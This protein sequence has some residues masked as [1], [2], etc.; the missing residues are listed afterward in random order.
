MQTALYN[1]TP[2]FPINKDSNTNQL[3]RAYKD[4]EHTVSQQG[5]QRG[6]GESHLVPNCESTVIVLARERQHSQLGVLTRLFNGR[7]V[8]WSCRWNQGVQQQQKAAVT[9]YLKLSG[10]NNSNLLS[11]CSGVQKPERCQ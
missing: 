3:R 11:Q 9:S 1:N 4:Q 6:K 5:R 2:E 8:I 7:A 10:F